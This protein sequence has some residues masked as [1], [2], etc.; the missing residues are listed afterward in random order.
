MDINTLHKAE[1]D[2]AIRMNDIGRVQLRTTVPLHFDRYG[3]NR[4]TGSLIL[5]DEATNETVAAGMIV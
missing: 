4:S 3:R 5:I 2:S 1:S